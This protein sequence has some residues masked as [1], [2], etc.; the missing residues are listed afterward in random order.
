M[1]LQ[2]HPRALWQHLNHMVRI[3]WDTL[4][5]CQTNPW[6]CSYSHGEDVC[7][8]VFFHV[9][10]VGGCDLLQ[11]TVSGIRYIRRIDP[12]GLNIVCYLPIRGSFSVFEVLEMT[13]KLGRENRGTCQSRKGLTEP[14]KEERRTDHG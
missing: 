6:I 11:N 9:I 7:V 1:D 5:M 4:Y 3:D 12:C 10:R 14:Q 2:L 8:S 13:L